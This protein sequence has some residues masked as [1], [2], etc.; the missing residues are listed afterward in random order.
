MW[1]FHALTRPELKGSAEDSYQFIASVGPMFEDV[2]KTSQIS[3]LQA[4]V[5]WTLGRQTLASGPGVGE[6]IRSNV[7]D[8]GAM[9]RASGF[10]VE[11]V[12]WSDLLVP[13]LVGGA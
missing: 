2:E 10:V 5:L 11:K 7:T 3:V 13:V 8:L 12:N 1:Q 4:L 6:D 9:I